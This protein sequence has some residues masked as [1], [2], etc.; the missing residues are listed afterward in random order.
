MNR[1]EMPSNAENDLG[2]LVFNAMAESLFRV[3]PN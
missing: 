3:V 1:L 2:A